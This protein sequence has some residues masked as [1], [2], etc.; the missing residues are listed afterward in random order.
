M[1]SFYS[2]PACKPWGRP[3]NTKG[4]MGE[5]P[6]VQGPA[7]LHSRRTGRTTEAFCSQVENISTTARVLESHAVE[8]HT[9]FIRSHFRMQGK[10]TTDCDGSARHRKWSESAGTL[11]WLLPRT[12]V[13]CPGQSCL[14]GMSNWPAHPL[15]LYGPNRRFTLQIRCCVT[16]IPG[17]PSDL[18]VRQP[19]QMQYCLI[20]MPPPERPPVPDPSFPCRSLNCCPGVQGDL[21]MS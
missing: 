5:A 15:H 3:E 8:A 10:L 18:P 6:E 16:P 19:V 2:V 7:T 9:V 12:Y 14:S 17:P 4:T 1:L 11:L 20:Q 21:Q 13:P